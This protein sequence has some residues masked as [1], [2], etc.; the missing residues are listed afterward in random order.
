MTGDIQLEP[1]TEAFTLGVRGLILKSSLTDQI[2]AALSAV[3]EDYFWVQGRKIESLAGVLAQ[4]RTQTRRDSSERFHL[5]RREL[6]VVGLIVK[7]LSNREIAKQFDLSEETVKRH[8]SN[9]FNK[10]KLS[11]RLELAIFAISHKL[12]TNTEKA[13]A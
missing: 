1:L 4:L 11:T 7:G 10:L 8:L 2:A 3:L 13:D 12:V 9:I 6:D 5:T